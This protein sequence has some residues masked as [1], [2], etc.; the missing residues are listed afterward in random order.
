VTQGI[1]KPGFGGF[2][3]SSRFK[4]MLEQG[5]DIVSAAV[6]RAPPNFG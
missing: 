2:E 6:L 3:L 4:K 1:L 5:V